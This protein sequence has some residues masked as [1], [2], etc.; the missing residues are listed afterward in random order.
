MFPSKE[1]D[2]ED[3]RSIHL[4]LFAWDSFNFL[5]TKNGVLFIIRLI[6]KGRDHRGI[7]NIFCSESRNNAKKEGQW[8][9]G[10]EWHQE[11]WNNA[12]ILGS[13]TIHRQPG[14]SFWVFCQDLATS[15]NSVSFT[16]RWSSVVPSNKVQHNT[17][18]SS[19]KGSTK[20]LMEVSGPGWQCLAASWG[21]LLGTG[22]CTASAYFS[23]YWR[24]GSTAEPRK[25]LR[26]TQF[27]WGSRSLQVTSAV[28]DNVIE[29]ESDYIIH[30]PK[31]WKISYLKNFLMTICP[32]NIF[33]FLKDWLKVL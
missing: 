15:E 28:F 18:W 14:L 4:P 25:Y 6:T 10:W 5:Q 16:F 7:L 2:I 22:P 30:Y 1:S 27:R 3:L 12:I 9:W 11:F 21:M 23:R 33:L 17:L 24:R 32:L 31:M 20:L 13:I 8:R 26:S 29:Y 19:W